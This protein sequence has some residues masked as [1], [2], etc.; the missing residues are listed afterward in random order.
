MPAEE[1][2]ESRSVEVRIEAP[3][4]GG[5]SGSKEPTPMEDA[6][7]IVL[8]QSVPRSSTMDVEDMVVGPGAPGKDGGW[9]KYN[10]INS[11]KQSGQYL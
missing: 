11:L 5:A 9:S 10:S 6:G 1:L 8:P 4:E 2:D 3:N 7:P